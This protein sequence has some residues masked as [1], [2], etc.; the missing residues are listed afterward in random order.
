MKRMIK[1]NV[2]VENVYVTNLSNIRTKSIEMMP[3]ETTRNVTDCVIANA[4]TLLI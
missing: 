3:Y 2:L 4:K 1:M